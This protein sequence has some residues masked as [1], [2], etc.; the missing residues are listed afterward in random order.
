MK[1]KRNEGRLKNE[2]AVVRPKLLIV[3]NHASFHGGDPN[4]ENEMMVNVIVPFREIMAEFNLGVLYLMHTPWME[5]D[6][7]RGTAAIFDAAA[8]VIAVTKP[9]PDTRQLTWTKRRSVRRQMGASEIEI[10]Y[11]A[12][13]YMIYPSAG[14]VVD[15]VLS[16]IAFPV[17]RSI[18]VKRLA[19]ALG[20][21]D[22]GARYRVEGMEKS[23]LLVN[24]GG[25]VVDKGLHRITDYI[26]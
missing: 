23:G 1:D 4:K 7:P 20:I 14:T 25:G 21:T 18:V 8:T 22:R 6:R 16:G 12:E 19:E 15:E 24:K 9:Q 2:L 26:Q 17:K 5:R 11:N 3:D 10:S 13:N